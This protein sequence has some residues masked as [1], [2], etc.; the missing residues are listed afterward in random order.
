MTIKT[1]IFGKLYMIAIWLGLL[2]ILYIFIKENYVPLGVILFLVFFS[3]GLFC[4]V[5]LSFTT[6]VTLSTKGIFVSRSMGI[7]WL[8]PKEYGFLWHEIKS[9]ESFFFT[10]IPFK[11]FW[12]D[13]TWKGRH[14]QI[15][16]GNLWTKKREAL[17]YI[18]DHVHRDIFKKSA[19]RL[20]QKYKK[21]L[22]K[23][24]RI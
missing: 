3:I 7:G 1:T 9:V 19:Y 15:L 24:A 2:Y 20:A 14:Q 17:V 16:L 21:K 18:A 22:E 6:R 12:I 5:I 10:F 23:K 11:I 4:M 13:G 8:M